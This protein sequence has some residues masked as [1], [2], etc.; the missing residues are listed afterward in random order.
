MTIVV[1]D[2]YRNVWNAWLLVI[3]LG[4]VLDVKANVSG[5]TESSAMKILF[6]GSDGLRNMR[7]F[8]LMAL[9]W[10]DS[11]SAITGKD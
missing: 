1:D 8:D 2:G 9:R 5:T 4:D 7:R 6:C 3:I 11:D 10:I